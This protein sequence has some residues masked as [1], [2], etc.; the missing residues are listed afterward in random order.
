MKQLDWLVLILFVGFTL[1]YGVAKGRGARNLRS[2]MLADKTMPWYAVA[3]SIM[4]TQASAI[5]F[6]STTGQAY[7]D[8]MR[9]VQFYFGLPVAMVILC[10]FA[11]PLFHRLNVYTAYEFLESRFDLKTRVLTGLIFL[12]SR[13]L[14]A[15]LSLYAPALILSIVLGWDMRLTVWLMGGVIVAYTVAGGVKGVNWNDFQQFVVMMGGMAVA[16]MMTVYLL[17]DDVSFPDAVSVAGLLGRLN[18]VDF[19][20]DW[21]NRYNFWSGLI[22]GMF[23]FLA[24]FGTDQ[25][26]VQRYLTGRSVTQSKLGLLFNGMAKVPMQF[27]IL[28]VGAMVFVFY[29][30]AAPPLFFNPQEESQVRASRLGAE[31]RQLERSYGAVHQRKKENVQAWLAADGQRSYE[32]KVA[33]GKSALESQARAEEI[34][35]RAVDLIRRSDP[36]ANTNDTNYVFLT[37]VTRY[38]PAGVVGLI[39]VVIFAATMSTTASELNSLA[40]CT[41]VDVY[42]RIITTQASERHYVMVSRAATAAWGLFAVM[43]SERASRLGTL[44]EAVNILGSLFYGTILGVFILAFAFR[45]VTGTAVFVAALLAEGLV[46]YLFFFTEISYLWY[47][48]F[49]SLTVVAAGLLLTGLSGIL[50]RPEGRN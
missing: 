40:T 39:I 36:Q 29:Q 37:F 32:A 19:S 3:L 30:F 24:Y 42:K 9:F 22:A 50:S 10:V 34:R 14:A 49:G 48:V 45:R 27:F 21:N 28:F 38:L 23:L 17:P 41:V 6:V 43:A 35:K 11:V 33:A 7:A 47:N 13:G 12:I 5:T 46:L 20:F 16:L 44:V 18:A 31:Y 25:S 26:Q 2:Y 4:A 1:I 15:S 8:G